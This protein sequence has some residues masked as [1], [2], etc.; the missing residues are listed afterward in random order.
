M[1][2]DTAPQLA[3]IVAKNPE[4]LAFRSSRRPARKNLRLKCCN[5]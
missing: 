5:N 3:D 2:G 4:L 1:V